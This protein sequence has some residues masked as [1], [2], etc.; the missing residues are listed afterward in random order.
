MSRPLKKTAVTKSH[1]NPMIA[2]IH[3]ARRD[4]ALDDGTYR[5]L[6]NRVTGKFSV[7]D[8]KDAE[9][10]AV[11]DEFKRLG[12]R[13]KKRGPK[14]AG[15][16]PLAPGD[17]AA[18][19]R[20]LWLALYHLGEVHDPREAALAAFGQRITGKAALQFMRAAQMDGLIKALRGWCDR[21]GFYQP[22]ADD[23]RSLLGLSLNVS[24][25]P[26]AYARASKMILI[27]IQSK[28]LGEPF[29]PGIK[30]LDTSALDPMIEALGAR[31]R[32]LKKGGDHGQ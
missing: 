29:P 8:L 3:C 14:R 21:V 17:E 19:A 2:K 16:R 9:L 1:R 6:L 22:Q 24:P 13:K 26:A 12:W 27:R 11:L 31:V 28:I 25:S 5:A 15:S 18:K 20:A 23:V 30:T 32:A 10:V 7:A 4:L